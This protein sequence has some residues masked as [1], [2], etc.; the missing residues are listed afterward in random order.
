MK[1]LESLSV[2]EFYSTIST[3][4][5]INEERSKAVENIRNSGGGQSD[6]GTKKRRKLAGN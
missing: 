2:D 6:D 3:Y 4:L 1:V 5:K